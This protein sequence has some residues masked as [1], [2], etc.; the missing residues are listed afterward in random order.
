MG[1]TQL[2]SLA[3]IFLSRNCVCFAFFCDHEKHVYQSTQPSETRGFDL[4]GAG[5]CVSVC[6]CVCVCL[7]LSLCVCVFRSLAYPCRKIN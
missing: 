2:A 5:V 4:R 3:I 1:I 6:L 7:S